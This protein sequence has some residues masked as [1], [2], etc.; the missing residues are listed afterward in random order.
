[1]KLK[2]IGLGFVALFTSVVAY[3]ESATEKEAGKLLNSMGMEAA[4]KQSMDQMLEIQLQQKPAL[5]PF[6]GV[7][8]QF[9]HKHMSYDE[10]KPEMIQIYAKAFTEAELKE[11]NRFYASP[12]GQKTIKVLPELMAKSGEIGGRRVQE[13]IGELQAMIEAEAARLKSLESQ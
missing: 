5:V 10:L 1:M 9:L 11:I 3:A 7:M 8:E 4:F 6:K 13:N 2:M 12:T